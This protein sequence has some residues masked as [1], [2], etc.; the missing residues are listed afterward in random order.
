M[1]VAGLA[2]HTGYSIPHAMSEVRRAVDLCRGLASLCREH[3]SRPLALRGPTGESNEL[4]LV[5]KGTF[6]TL[7]GADS[8]LAGFLGPII[9]AFAA[10]NCVISKPASA[11]AVVASVA[12]NRLL[13]AGIPSTAIAFS[14]GG[15]AVGAAL[16]AHAGCNGVAFEGNPK[17]ASAVNRLLAAREGPILPLVMGAGAYPEYLFRFANERT[18]TINTTAAGGNASLMVDSDLLPAT[19]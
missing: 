10:G 4:R 3:F 1:L 14:P 7:S 5:G 9:A 8:P 13:E 15:R 12:F 2:L 17:S 16:V 19:S 11:A 6:V 18:T